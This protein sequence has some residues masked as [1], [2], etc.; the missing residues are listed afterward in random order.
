M[1]KKK[2]S[3]VCEA[4]WNYTLRYDSWLR[5]I[6]LASATLP[7]CRKCKRAFDEIEVRKMVDVL[8]RYL[9]HKKHAKLPIEIA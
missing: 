6:T 9:S 2:R 1:K 5:K 3:H 7:K 8:Y 4:E